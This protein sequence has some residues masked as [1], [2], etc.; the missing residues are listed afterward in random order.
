MAG[1]DISVVGSRPPTGLSE[2]GGI[3]SLGGGLLGGGLGM[4]GSIFSAS[5]ARQNAQ[6]M[7]DFQERMSSTAHQREVADLRAAGLNPILSAMHGGA[8]T[9]GGAQGSVPDYGEH[10][11]EVGKAIS[12]SA[13]ML[14]MELPLAKSQIALNSATKLDKQTSA[15]V[16][17]QLAEK[18]K[19]DKGVADATANRINTLTNWEAAEYAQKLKLMDTNMKLNLSSAKRAD[20]DSAYS[21]AGAPWSIAKSRLGQL[22][23]D[24]T[25]GRG[26]YELERP[27]IMRAPTESS[28]RFFEGGAG[29]VY[30]GTN[31]ASATGSW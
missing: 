12:N 2:A 28:S 10:G 24:L 26:K 9:P 13:R 4:L 18:V 16:N 11:K 8:S 22:F 7:M 25:G 17:E 15:D 3:A 23:I 5:Q 27:S 1:E 29:N 19:S 20:Y 14:S 6:D 30:G 21:W 31:S